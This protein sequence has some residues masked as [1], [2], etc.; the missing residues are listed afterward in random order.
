MAPKRKSSAEVE[1]AVKRVQSTSSRGTS[2]QQPEHQ[3][4]SG[5]NPTAMTAE[6]VTIDWITKQ[7][8]QQITPA[9]TAQIDKNFDHILGFQ[10]GT[11]QGRQP[12]TSSL[13]QEQGSTATTSALT[14]H[15]VQQSVGTSVAQVTS[16]STG[17]SGIGTPN[18]LLRPVATLD[19]ALLVHL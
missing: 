2:E 15:N 16:A 19:L 5:A 1:L 8:V 11:H 6:Q 12:T 13:Q 10:Q 14:D 7:V 18:D 4:A 9:I 3:H 17:R